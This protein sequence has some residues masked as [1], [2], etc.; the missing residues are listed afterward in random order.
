MVVIKVLLYCCV[1]ENGIQCV[2][3]KLYPAVADLGEGLTS[4]P[5]VNQ[6]Q[7]CKAEVLETESG[8]CFPLYLKG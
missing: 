7:S 4:P 2:R 8:G 6:K 3:I 5:F 1:A